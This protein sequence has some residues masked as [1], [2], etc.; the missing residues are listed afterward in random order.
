MVFANVKMI[1]IYSEETDIVEV[2]GFQVVQLVHLLVKM[3]ALFV[4]Q[5]PFT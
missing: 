2:V 1:N 4:I 3:C 5:T